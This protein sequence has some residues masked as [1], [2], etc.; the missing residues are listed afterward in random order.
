MISIVLK[1]IS[2]FAAAYVDDMGVHSMEWSLHM[3]HLV[4]YLTTM[5]NANLTLKLKKSAFAK[6]EIKMVG[7]YVGSG[8]HRPDPEKTLV[9]QHLEKPTDKTA[10]RRALGMFSYFRSYVPDFAR[11]ARPLTDLT[12][13]GA[14]S[15]IPW[16][17]EQDKAFDTLCNAMC[18]MPV[19]A[20]PRFGEP[21]FLQTDASD[22]AVGCCL[23]QWDAE[24]REHPI[25]YASMKLSQSQQNW[26]VVE[27]EAFAVI[28]AL[29]KYKSIIFG[30]EVTVYVDHNPLVFLTETT[31]KT[32]KLCRWLLAL[33]EFNVKFLYK[34]GVENRVADCLSRI[35]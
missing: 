18:N 17:T 6:P 9:L 28:W 26:S 33:Q 23:G 11:I 32:G 7:H 14:P 12:A 30:A 34:K 22:A 13:K 5:R 15:K 29:N 1:P 8:N 10:L 24:H 27:K 16:S 20:A 31:P 35:A 21:F 3:E 4:A 2:N 25:A 19:M